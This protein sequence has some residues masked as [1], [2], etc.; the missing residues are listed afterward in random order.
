ME[1]KKDKKQFGLTTWAVNNRKTVY[2][3][4]FII[5][6]A[7]IGAYTSMPKEN[8][9]ELQ[10]PEIYVGIAYPGN[11]PEIIADKI[12]D[13]IE[14][15]LNSIDDVDEITSTSI[16]GY[17]TIST[18]FN[19]NVTA[20]DALQDVK[21]AVDK[22]RAK[23]EF[24][25]DLPVEPNIFELDMSQMAIMNI[26]LSGD[27]STEQLKD[28]GEVIEEKIEDLTEI[29]EVDIRGVQEK[30]MK[31]ELDRYKA[32]AVDVSFT[33]VENA[34]NGENITM[35]GGEMQDG[36]TKRTIQIEG[37]FK[38][39]QEIENIIIKQ[40]DYKPIYLKDV[41]KVSFADSD[42]SS[43][44][45][46][47]GR[48]VVMLDVK[49][50]GG[51]NLLDA[52]DKIMEIL[53]NLK[54]EKVI[55]SDIKISVTNDQSDKTREMVSNLENSIYF[56]ILLVVGV[57]LFFL[58]IRNAL[59][60]G[61]A[62]PLSMLLSFMIL[63]GMGITLNT[64]VL[65][66]M[67]LALGMLVDNGIVVVENIYRLM[68]DGMDS[69]KAA[70]Y[71]VGEVAWPIIASTATTL[72]AFIP[73]AFWPG[74]M[75]EFMKYLPITLIIVLGSSLFVALVINPVFT[76][77][78]MKLESDN[79]GKS[80]KRTVI[81]GGI[82]IL[83]GILFFTVSLF[84]ANVLIF[85]GLFVM[86][87]HFFLSPAAT[88]FQNKF[89]PILESAYERMLT[90]AIKKRRA[91]W[92]FIGTFFLL[93]FSGILLSIFPPKVLFFPES[94]PNYANVFIEMPIGTDIKETNRITTEVEKIIMN[95]ILPDEIKDTV[96][97]PHFQHIVQS[98]IAQVGDGASDPS[99]GI[100]MGNTPH[101]ARVSVNFAEFK[102]RGEYN[103]SDLLKK[104]TEGLRHKFPAD[105]KITV[106]K[107]ENGPPSGSAI[108]I[109]VTGEKKYNEI[110]AEAMKIQTFLERKNV[111]GV[112]KLSM[113]VETGKPELKIKIDRDKAR[114]FNTSTGQIAMAIRTSLFGKD[115][116]T[117]KEGDE[118]YD[119]NL[120]FDEEGRD[121][122]DALLD[123][124]LIF[125]N[126]KGQMLRIPIR[127]LVANPTPTNTYSQVIHKDLVPIVTITS[128]VDPGFNDTEVVNELKG[129]LAD[130]ET[131][132]LISDGVSYKFTGQQE[133]Q[134]EQMAFL[135]KALLIAVFLILIVIVGQFNS[136]STP[137]I[138][139]FA[140]V[141]SL[142]GVLLGEVIFQ[143]EFVIMMTM[144]GII[145]LA[146]VVVNNAIVLIDYTNLLR[147]EKREELGLGEFESL[148]K[149]DVTKAIIEAGKTRLRPVLLTAI[150]TVL[151]L[152]PLATGF[153]IDFAG[154]L[155]N[156]DPDIYFGGDNNNFFGPMSTTI[157][158]GLTFA[159]FLTLV[160]IPA[161]YLLF[162]QFKIWLYKIFK[163]PMRTNL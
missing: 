124:K 66:A 143:L 142:I 33:T 146:G 35:S 123:Q 85:A 59:F 68:D 47:Y 78:W 69:F 9:P 110:I 2:L 119:I 122:I 3:L 74:I 95:E 57:L 10:I 18:K 75:G 121:N 130:F 148:S 67:V 158:F 26:N 132:G 7:G 39:A 79:E 51:E 32:E 19:F 49:K 112:E 140:V 40:D 71:G 56:G 151:G 4:S 96:G 155:H 137:V 87:N 52:S 120:R 53:A 23:K 147:V 63:N 133:E 153:N 106:A 116:S 156:Y 91:L 46:E 72:A 14:K 144:I 29:S 134:A 135:S 83:L 161:M 38:S 36:N 92:V 150:T 12:A 99:R 162:F 114:L 43:Y 65:F 11:S 16:N 61:V 113:D 117:F 98:V 131:E 139:L 41:A 73:L 109:E 17:V 34:I 24:P 118:T 90:A 31:I 48:T 81:V 105:V 111:S 20:K 22:A 44:A 70:K 159:T 126:N 94:E 127:S 80:H 108:S 76:A 88:W 115:I 97:M 15:E 42:T 5:F 55:P 141:F 13:P 82:L 21:D 37:E 86:F 50:R 102:N 84:L 28:Y 107:N 45:R 152:V 54:I 138:I 93:I 30:E 149:A 6:V 8:F 27:Y 129:L 77:V 145:S 60:V 1:E 89:L 160:V 62:I 136:F 125:R 101:K 128:N 64:M 104:I 25:S 58:G 100:S 103:T 154:F 157:I 163:T